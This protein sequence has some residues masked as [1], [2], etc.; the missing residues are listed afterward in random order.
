MYLGE[1]EGYVFPAD[2]KIKH[3]STYCHN[4][5]YGLHHEEVYAWS[6]DD[7]LTEYSIAGLVFAESFTNEGDVLHV[8]DKFLEMPTAIQSKLD[9]GGRAIKG[10]WISVKDALPPN[11]SDDW[12][13]IVLTKQRGR[14]KRV[15]R[16]GY[17]DGYHKRFWGFEAPS[18][19]SVTHWMHLPEPPKEV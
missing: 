17:W 7:N 16:V 14:T 1:Y 2:K 5:Y 12:Y 6:D 9:E 8:Y 13:N 3:K 11:G 10:D 18:D 19:Y 15:V 4:Y